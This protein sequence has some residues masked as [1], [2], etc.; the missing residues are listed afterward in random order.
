[1]Q[2][3]HFLVVKLY[4]YGPKYKIKK[5][6]YAENIVLILDLL[7]KNGAGINHVS[8]KGTVLNN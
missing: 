3:T 2:V 7:L 6:E 8:A 1:M 4:N 5:S